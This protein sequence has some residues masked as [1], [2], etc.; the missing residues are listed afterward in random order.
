[1]VEYGVVPPNDTT[2]PKVGPDKTG[3]ITLENFE[4]EQEDVFLDPPY[5]QRTPPYPQRTR[6]VAEVMVGPPHRGKTTQTSFPS[7]GLP[8][9]PA[10]TDAPPAPVSFSYFRTYCGLNKKHDTKK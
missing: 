6:P 2:D 7:P 9:P 4:S 5:P 3:R 8:A 10:P 1:M